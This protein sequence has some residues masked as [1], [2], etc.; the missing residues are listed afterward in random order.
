MQTHPTKPK[1]PN[2][3][4]T[5]DTVE[6]V[7]LYTT[8][9]G[10]VVLAIALFG[11]AFIKIPTSI[12][13]A[14]VEIS[15]VF[16]PA[17][18]RLQLALESRYVES[19]IPLTLAWTAPATDIPGSFLFAY[20]CVNGLSVFMENRDGD[21]ESI[22]C[23]QPTEP[24]VSGN[25]IRIRLTS[26]ENR[27]LD[28]PLAVAFYPEGDPSPL[29]FSR[30]LVTVEN[31]RIAFSPSLRPDGTTA[32][33]TN[34]TDV[35]PQIDTATPP[36]TR[37]PKEQTPATPQRGAGTSE[38]FQIPRIDGAA[39]TAPRTLSGQ[40]DLSVKIMNVGYIDDATKGFVISNTVE[41]N[42]ISAVMFAVENNGTN[43]SGSWD[44]AAILPT[45]PPYIFQSPTQRE[46]LPGERIEF[47]MGFDKAKEGATSLEIKINIDP[48]QRI[49]ESNE[50]NNST[51]ATIGIRN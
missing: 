30:A 47:T 33:S 26:T 16:Y 18:T 3:L 1:L 9:T 15:S 2:T 10:V 32:T 12:Q 42:N 19:G 5:R 25:Q 49:S 20:K 39:Q 48:S 40:S 27:F 34:A 7:V 38:S 31:P 50:T 23:E 37:P 17:D 43:S 35:S 44:F 22:S 14:A 13:T 36:A 8:I 6:K 51:I 41:K 21:Y 4:L 28:V 24:L 29:F 46:L 45:N 11:A